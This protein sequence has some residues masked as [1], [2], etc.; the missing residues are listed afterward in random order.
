MVNAGVTVGLLFRTLEHFGD[1]ISNVGL[2]LPESGNGLPDPLNE[3]RNELE[4][5]FKMQLYDGR[6]SHKLSAIT[7]DYRDVPE[8]DPDRRYFCPWVT[9][10]TAD[11]TA[12]MALGARHFRRW[13]PAFAG[14][15]LAAAR[16]SW[17]CLCANPDHVEPDQQAFHTGGYGAGDKSHR[18]W[19]AVELWE[20]TGAPSFLEWF[21]NRAGDCSFHRLGPVWYDVGDLA[22]GAYLEASRPEPRE[23]SL[24]ERFRESLFV[25]ARLDRRMNFLVPLEAA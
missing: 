2:D 24:V 23:A 16:K 6:V 19:A 10:A 4:W 14:Q 12:M 9:A 1:R 3:V 5:L 15:C 17:D 11:F 25:R 7:F 18:L 21:E 22:L 13:D 20:T 8:T